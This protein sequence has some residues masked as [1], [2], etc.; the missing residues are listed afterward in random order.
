MPTEHLT[1]D[2]F[3]REFPGLVPAKRQADAPVKRK[4]SCKPV[5]GAVNISDFESFQNFADS[6]L[7]KTP[8]RYVFS[9]PNYRPPSANALYRCKMKRTMEQGR[10]C[11]DFVTLYGRDVPKATGP[12]RVAMTVY[13]GTRQRKPDADEQLYKAV[14]DALKACGLLVD[15]RR[16]MCVVVPTDFYRSIDGKPC[17]VLVIE[18]FP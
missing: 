6:M 10:E 14:L 11:K 5:G 12:R 15:D 8:G 4:K 16:E 9:I 17:T 18:D 13:L 1:A 7:R 2:E 3:R